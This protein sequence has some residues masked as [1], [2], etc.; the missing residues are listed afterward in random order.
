MILVF[1]CILPHAILD[2]VVDDEVELFVCKAVVL[3]QHA[4]DL[5]DGLAFARIV[6]LLGRPD[7]NLVFSRHDK[8]SLPCLNVFGLKEASN[9]THERIAAGIS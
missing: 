1:F 9:P 2:I 3:G 5:V 8:A 6:L 4:V 7:P